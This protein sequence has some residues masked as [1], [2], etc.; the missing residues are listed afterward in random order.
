MVY[1]SGDSARHRSGVVTKYLHTEWPPFGHR[2]SFGSEIK[3]ILADYVAK[4][5][6][7]VQQDRFWVRTIVAAIPSTLLPVRIGAWRDLLEEP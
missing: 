2:V 6:F 1:A 7:A 4:L 3:N 5:K